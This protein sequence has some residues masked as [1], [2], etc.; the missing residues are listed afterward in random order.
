M[1]LI[2]RRFI[3][4][5]ALLLL[6]GI[7]IPSYAIEIEE[8]NPVEPI[9]I[10]LTTY[11]AAMPITNSQD[12]LITFGG[13]VTS[14]LGGFDI[15]IVPNASLSANIPA[16]NAFNRAAAQW[17]A[18]ISDPITVTID[19]Q[20][21]ALGSGIIGSASSVVL[22]A[23]YNT[24]RNQLVANSAPELDDA[25][26]ASLPTAVT[27]AATVP[28]GFSLS[29]NLLGSKANLKAMGFT[30]LDGLFG[31]SDATI[32]FSSAFSFDYDNSDGVTPGFM[33]FETVAAHEIGHALGFFSSVDD[34]D[35]DV[36][37]GIPGAISP[38]TLDLFR[39]IDSASTTLDPI[40]TVT[41]ATADRNLVPG[42]NGI[43]DFGADT[44]GVG[45]EFRMSTGL[46]QGD[47]RQASHWKDNALTGIYIG[48]L[49][50]TLNFNTIQQITEADFRA[51]DLIGYDIAPIPEPSTYALGVL[52]L[53][54]LYLL[55]R[56]RVGCET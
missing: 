22:Q 17:E 11:S 16:L 54:S 19:G 33:D 37:A 31:V 35:A 29:G 7:C 9:P 14:N 3:S 30:G 8:L 53:A 13:I 4:T 39:F 40:N 15:V 51:L 32:T 46:T 34:V 10:A 2:Q 24:I 52:G 48:M 45:T 43:T 20:L 42:A 47:G 25:I 1:N 44:W 21:A 38:T 5:A 23:P 36:Q 27:F 12:S 55:R 18:R 28:V 41:F 26:V 49:D 56:K 6:L 50:P